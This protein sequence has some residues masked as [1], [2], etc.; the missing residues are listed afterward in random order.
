MKRLCVFLLPALLLAAGNL[1]LA[2]TDDPV[3]GTVDTIGGTTFDWQ[4]NGPALRMLANSDGN[5]IHALWMYSASTS[6]TTFPDRN[7]RYNFFDYAAGAWSFIDPDF[8][9]S[10]VNVFAERVGL[11]HAQQRP[12]QRRRGRLA[13]LRHAAR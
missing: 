8:M 10:G 6:G 3:L 9:Q 12:D 4:A 1:A 7:M 11:R 5:G 13:P 2:G